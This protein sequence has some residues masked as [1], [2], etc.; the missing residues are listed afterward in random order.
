L[1]EWSKNMKW[2]LRTI[3]RL[4]L[5]YIPRGIA[6]LVCAEYIRRVHH[7]HQ[8]NKSTQNKPVTPTPETKKET[9]KQK[10]DSGPQ[11]K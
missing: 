10:P 6:V 3:S 11:F 9:L 4:T 5:I 7:E 8:N 2:D 1:I